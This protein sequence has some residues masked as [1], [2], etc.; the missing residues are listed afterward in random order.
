[1]Q[2]VGGTIITTLAD[3][4]EKVAGNIRLNRD[5]GLALL[6]CDDVKAVGEMANIVRQRKHGDRTYYVVNVHINYTNVC[7][8]RCRF[9][10]FSRD[11]GED[12]AYTMS[13]E[14]VVHRARRVR[15]IGATE[16]HIVGGL[17]PALPYDYYLEMMRR[18]STDFP[19]V[20]LQAFTAV[21]ID[22]ISRISGRSVEDVLGDLRDAGL[23]SLPG[24]G[25]EIFSPRV[26]KSLCPKKIP[27]EIWLEVMRTAHDMGI[28]SNATM[29][30]GHVERDDEI[31]D[32]LLRLRELQDETGGFMSFI[33]LAF[34]PE[35]TVMVDLRR[36]SA[37][38][39]LKMLSVG[40]LMLDNFEHVKAFWVMLGTKLAQVS[41]AFGVNDL[42][43]TVVEEK[44][45]H[46]AGAKT[47]Q[48]LTVSELRRMIEEAGRIPVER[49]TLYREVYR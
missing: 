1:M 9:C 43:G 37:V 49:D 30:Y 41:Q 36:T 2:Y 27:G 26:R 7:V 48:Y 16:I 39:D 22:F 33:P 10:A 12:G 45:T 17:N 23:G 32:H 38:R 40:R 8:N 18:L 3:I 21:E 20:H 24:G 29:L 47:P 4:R 5:E 13:V 42:D 19:G 46:S 6:A 14:E 31:I 44:I 28:R 11:E 34:H 35:N 25:A 15:E